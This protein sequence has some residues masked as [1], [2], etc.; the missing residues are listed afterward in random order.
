MTPALR[1]SRY[2]FPPLRSPLLR[3]QKW[4]F[5]L[6]G[7]TVEISVAVRENTVTQRTYIPINT[8]A[9][10]NPVLVSKTKITN[11]NNRMIKDRLY[12]LYDTITEIDMYDFRGSTVSGFSNDITLALTYP[13]ANND[14]IVDDDVTHTKYRESVLAMVVLNPL[15][16]RWELVSGSSVDTLTNKVTVNVPH[17][18]VYALASMGPE[19]G[20]TAKIYPNP[21]KPNSGI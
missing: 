6:F 12:I 15:L 21:F 14:T 8:D 5:L 16:E 20:K 2:S 4:S 7:T 9:L 10:D 11:A 17:F 3:Q 19:Y 18:S 13:D 1:A